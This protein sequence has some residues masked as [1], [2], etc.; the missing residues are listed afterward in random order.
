MMH[1]WQEGA[2][3]DGLEDALHLAAYL[4]TATVNTIV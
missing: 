4:E 3:M 2:S 1:K